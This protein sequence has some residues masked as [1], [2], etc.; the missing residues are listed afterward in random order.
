MQNLRYDQNNFTNSRISKKAT[1]L[2]LLIKQAKI[3]INFELDFLGTTILKKNEWKKIFKYIGY[4]G[5]YYFHTQ[6]K[7][8]L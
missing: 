4:S 5:D 6:K 3:E 7:L 2:Y 1:Y 8:G